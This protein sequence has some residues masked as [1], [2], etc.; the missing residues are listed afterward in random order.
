MKTYPCSHLCFSLLI[1]MA[2]FANSSLA[3]QTTD[4][5]GLWKWTFATP[6]GQNIDSVLELTQDGQKLTGIYRSSRG[7][8]TEIKN[9]QIKGNEISFHVT[10]TFQDQDFT[11]AFQGKL[12]G[13]AIDGNVRVLNTDRSWTWEAKREIPPADP[14]GTWTWTSSG[15]DGQSIE[16][17]LTLKRDGNKLTG[18]Y[19]S[20]RGET[21]I[22]DGAI[23]GNK[24]AF[25]VVRTG[26]EDRRITT[27]FN[28]EIKGDEI[29]GTIQFIAGGENRTR[30]WKARRKQVQADP[31][32]DWNLTLSTP[33]GNLVHANLQIKVDGNKITGWIRGDDWETELAEA[34]IEKDQLTFQ[35]VSYRDGERVVYRSKATV[36]GNVINGSVQFRDAQGDNLTLPWKAERR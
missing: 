13:D 19:E 14:T 1:T 34:K 23:S 31:A 35:T 22:Q 29:E 15:R 12:Q 27:D 24:I 18:K 4:A 10:R 11:M 33:N 5:S 17:S 6:N 36:E 7:G 3:A 21:A 28:G 26:R 2:L 25:K 8:E 30:D 16:S 9:G 32:G 20:P